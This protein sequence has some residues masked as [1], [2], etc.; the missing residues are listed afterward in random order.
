MRTIT[1]AAQAGNPRCQLA[2]EIF[3][4]MATKYT[5][6]FAAAMGGLDALVFTAGIGE[7][8]PEIRAI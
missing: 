4:Y 3:A 6:A 1:E 7:N 2:M 8:S 5:G